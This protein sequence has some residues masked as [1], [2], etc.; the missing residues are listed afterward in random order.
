MSLVSVYP[1][2]K[3]VQMKHQGHTIYEIPAC[4]PDKI[5]VAEPIYTNPIN[6]AQREVIG[7]SVTPCSPGEGYSILH[8]Y[9]TVQMV[10]DHLT[11]QIEP[12]PIPVDIVAGDLASTFGPGF[13]AIDG[14]DPSAENLAAARAELR[15][16]FLLEVQ[17]ADDWHTRG[18]GVKIRHRHRLA[19]RSL[20][21]EGRPWVREIQQRIEKPCVACGRDILAKAIVCEHCGTNLVKFYSDMKIEPNETEDPAVYAFFMNRKVAAAKKPPFQPKSERMAEMKAMVAESA[22]QR[23]QKLEEAMTNG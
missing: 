11:E 5:K 9:D 2:M 14:D 7:V 23:A 10:K 21:D 1:E 19:A 3:Q 15:E 12:K 16:K 18:E 22:A 4:E 17:Q 6:D 8:I 13:V 20:G